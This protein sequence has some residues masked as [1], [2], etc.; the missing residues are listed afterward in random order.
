MTREERMTAKDDAAAAAQ[1]EKA[2]EQVPVGTAPAQAV[3]T[4]HAKRRGRRPAALAA[5]DLVQHAGE[6]PQGPRRRGRPPSVAVGA[7]AV[8]RQGVEKEGK[9]RGRRGRKPAASKETVGPKEQ[10]EEVVEEEE[11]AEEEDEASGEDD[12]WWDLEVRGG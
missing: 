3:G 12:A 6:L 9:G 7:A 5:A 4:E 8:A 1:E 10:V 11:E 2:V